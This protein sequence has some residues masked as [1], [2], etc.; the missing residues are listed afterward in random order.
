MSPG[1]LQVVRLPLTQGEMGSH[2]K[3]VSTGVTIST[4]GVNFLLLPPSKQQEGRDLYSQPWR[5]IRHRLLSGN[6]SA[7]K[8]MND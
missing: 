2:G 5:T 6:A 7:S 3:V 4:S 1:S 8:C